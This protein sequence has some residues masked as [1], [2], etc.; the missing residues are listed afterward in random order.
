MELF[1]AI[2]GLVTFVIAFVWGVVSS[3]CY[4]IIWYHNLMVDLAAW[5]GDVGSF[6]DWLLSGL[7]V[8]GW[9]FAMSIPALFWVGTIFGIWHLSRS[10]R[11][12]GKPVRIDLPPA[13][14]KKRQEEAYAAYLE[15]CKIPWDV[16]MER[17]NRWQAGRLPPNYP[18]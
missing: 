1:G 3:A 16:R 12:E 11:R 14:L 2:F 5:N 18:R 6:G 17:A 7:G 13:E 10:E 8:L 4:E 15:D 9:G